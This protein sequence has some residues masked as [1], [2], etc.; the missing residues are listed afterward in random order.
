MPVV[1][2]PHPTDDELS[3]ALSRGVDAVAVLVRGDVVALRYALLIEHLVPNVQLVVTLFD[4]TIADQLVRTVPNCRVTS[5]ADVA[6]PSIAGACLSDDVLAVHHKTIIGWRSGG[7]VRAPWTHRPSVSTL[8]R[9]TVT[10]QMRPYDVTTRILLSGFLGLALILGSDWLVSFAARDESPVRAL[11]DAARVIATVGPG[12]T[13]GRTPAWYLLLSSSS[14][15]L[16]IGFTAL[17]TA[18]VVNRVRS[19]RSVGLLGARTVPTRDHVVVVGLGQVGLR[20]CTQ[21]R[22]LKVP[23]VAV[24]R[25]PEATNLRLAKE[26]KVPVIIGEAADRAVLRRLSLHRARALAAM[27]AN[28]LDNVEVAIA[29]LAVC[30]SVRIV[31][32]A[33]ENEVIAETRSLF[34]IG[35]VRDVSALTALAVTLSLKGEPW[36]VVYQRSNELF[37]STHTPNAQSGPRPFTANRCACL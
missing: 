37:V 14:M 19:S 20:L 21:L 22:R 28:D 25:D 10:A 3:E 26:A 1:H 7:E 5:P 15:L 30:P 12:N 6:V 23:V 35:E 17:F 32:R 11:Y 9:N 29:A 8:V 24:E 33:G 31:L 13:G 16:T 34:S 27:G 2:L 4:R 18:G 36:E